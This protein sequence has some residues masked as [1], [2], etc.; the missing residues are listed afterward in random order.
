VP[1][2][3][4]PLA[5]WKGH[6]AASWLAVD[7]PAWGFSALKRAEAGDHLVLRVFNGSASETTGTLRLGLPI[8][9]AQ[10]ARM[11]E[12]P[13]EAASLDEGCLTA[14]LRPFEVATWLLTP[15]Q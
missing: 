11:D 3:A 14:T 6:A 13:L 7:Q 9:G 10:R 5:A 12:T 15:A 8:A 4:F 1:V 2:A